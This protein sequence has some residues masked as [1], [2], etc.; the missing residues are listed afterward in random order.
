MMIRSLVTII[1]VPENVV[2]IED[3]VAIL[4]IVPIILDTLARLCQHSSR[5][6]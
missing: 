3:I 6:P 4:V 2:D 1:L 5:V